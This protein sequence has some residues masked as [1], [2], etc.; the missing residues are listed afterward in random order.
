MRWKAL[1]LT[2]LVILTLSSF[3]GYSQDKGFGL[4]IILGEPTG[5][6]GKYWLDESWAIDAGLAYSFAHPNKTF[7]FHADYL[8]HDETLI[9]S[10]L[11]LPVYYGIGARLHAGNGG[12]NTFGARGVIGIVW[13]PENTPFDL[14]IEL[15]PVFN[16]FPETSLHLDLAVGGRYYF[17]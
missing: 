8:F 2:A 5:V 17:K 4:G 16:L 1:S 13:I 7:S 10:S 12:G 11:R 9:R 3:S 6:S 15:A 14:F